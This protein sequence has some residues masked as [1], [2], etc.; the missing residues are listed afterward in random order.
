MQLYGT[1][2][3]IRRALLVCESKQIATINISLA[4]RAQL[5]DDYTRRTLKVIRTL[6]RPTIYQPLTTSHSECAVEQ[7]PDTLKIDPLI[8]GKVQGL[9]N[10]FLITLHPKS[11]QYRLIELLSI[12]AR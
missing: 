7:P 12:A 4:R 2:P 6:S 5:G 3:T 1:S 10:I 9:I 8:D 11:T